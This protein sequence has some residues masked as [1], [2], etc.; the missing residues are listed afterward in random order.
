MKVSLLSSHSSVHAP[1]VSGQ[2][3]RAFDELASR[4]NDACHSGR[5]ANHTQA[6]N[7]NSSAMKMS[8]VFESSHPLSCTTG[9]GEGVGA[10]VPSPSQV[11]HV[12]GQIVSA[13]FPGTHKTS[14]TSGRSDSHR[15]FRI[16]P[17]ASKSADV[18]SQSSTHLPHVSSHILYALDGCSG[19]Q[20]VSM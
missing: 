20:Y 19:L 3:S 5:A 4:H 10:S 14:C 2:I 11:S 16:L 1:H 8:S 17:C 18:S 12:S 6:W 13:G 9:G 15:Q 7:S